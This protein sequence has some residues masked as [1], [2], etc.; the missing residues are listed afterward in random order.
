MLDLRDNLIVVIHIVY[1]EKDENES[2][3]FAS[4]MKSLYLSI[5][6]MK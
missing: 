4:L 2:D 3:K 6:F 1:A 5:I